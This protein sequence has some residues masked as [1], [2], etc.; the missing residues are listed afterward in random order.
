[1]KKSEPQAPTSDPKVG[2]SAVETEGPVEATEPEAAEPEPWTWTPERVIEWNAYYDFY[3][4][5]LVLVLV[6]VSSFTLL[7]SSSTWTHLQTGRLIA[8]KGSP[9]LAEPFA[10]PR[11]GQSWTNVSW[12]FDL[13]SY[14]IYAAVEALEVGEGDR[15]AI[16]AL[17][18]L[19][20]LLR[21]LTA[22]LLLGIRHAGPGRWWGAI[23]AAL[24]LGVVISPAGVALGGIATRGSVL[25]ETWGLFLLGVE[26]LL[27]HR[28]Y[29]QGKRRALYG[30]VPLFVLWANVD[31]SFASG[32]ILL[33]AAV[34]GEAIQ[35]SRLTGRETGQ[36]AGGGRGSRGLGLVM[37]AVCLAACLATPFV[38]KSLLA[39]FAP[40]VEGLRPSGQA[41]TIDQL[42][43]FGQEASRFFGPVVYGRLVGYYLILVSTGLGSF[44]LNRRDFRLSRLLMF[45]AAAGLWALLNRLQD[46]FALVWA[47]TL[48]L[49]GQEWYQRVFGTEGRVGL[50]WRMWS[51]GGRLVTLGVV[52][53]AILKAMTGFGN[54]PFEPTFGFGYDPDEFA[55]EAA[56]FLSTA[57]IEGQVLNL[58]LAQGDALNWRAYPSRRPFLDT[59][60]LLASARYID[61]L[62]KVRRGLAN[63]K[64]EEWKPILDRYGVSVVMVDLQNVTTES[65]ISRALSE[66]PEWIGFYDDGD[67]MMFGRADASAGD[68]A[69]FKKARL[70]PE[71]LAFRTEHPVRP[72]NRPPSPFGT[73]DR[74]FQAR[75]LIPTQPRVKAAQRWLNRDLEAEGD[76]RVGPGL[77]S[78][79]LA[80]QETRNALS[81]KPD[82]TDAFFVQGLAYRRL[83]DLE[84]R[85]LSRGGEIGPNDPIPAPLRIRLLQRLTSLNDAI[86]T[87]PVP[88]RTE[89]ARDTLSRMYGELSSVYQSLGFLDLGR[90]ALAKA[91]EL[92]PEDQLDPSARQNLDEL[93][94]E[95]ELA[96][97]E[98]EQ[99][100]LEGSLDP[101]QI[102][103]AAL[104]RG[105]ALLA[106]QKLEDAEASGISLGSVK[107][108]LVDLFCDIG[109]P[110]RALPYLDN[111]G[112]DPNLSTGPGTAAFRQGRVYFLLGNYR[113]AV[114]LWDQIAIPQLKSARAN[115]SM[116]AGL[117]MLRANPIGAVRS[118]MDVPAQ[119]RQ[120][121][122]WEYLVGLALLE[123]GEPK[124]AATRF[125]AA[126]RL[127]PD[128][129]GRSIVEEY[130]RRIG[131]DIPARPASESEKPK[132]AEA[133]AS[134]SG[135][136]GASA[137]AALQGGEGVEEPK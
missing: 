57:P 120:Q 46:V 85:L 116:Q 66:S 70:D 15:Y 132:E 110:D 76:G 111:I 16:G 122:E 106:I 22:L 34:I 128:L 40:L 59:R 119:V 97:T 80:I 117:G 35:G 81:S 113:T 83:G 29:N 77:A 72:Y 109:Q 47:A 71:T 24:A 6:F 3:V 1:M 10:Y 89:Y 9:V 19:H 51:V 54:Q 103:V 88:P 14:Q 36:G 4:A 18:A 123:G 91:I 87:A 13:V 95:V 60:R 94:E 78:C 45:V 114:E 112:E 125:Q 7:S 30:L 65:P 121:A 131:A 11:L 17:V 67:V 39:A 79:L 101:V 68:V 102:A 96:R 73:L 53:A 25:P 52:T 64:Q 129:V 41:R 37:V 58:K 124:Y 99:A 82:D 23:M 32:L 137:P 115:N 130:L 28:A 62:E 104:Q 27:L 92:T 105:V 21:G 69:Y 48:T 134:A 61:D 100:D 133:T 86:R 43:V 98:L 44:V 84:S 49:N 8:E 126:L 56:D 93:T 38:H 63:R 135:T 55:F 108:R 74:V 31:E 50:G 12:L 5:A 2:A 26:L 20:A 107:W 136:Q 90:D 75:V 127:N 42:P 118:A 33:V